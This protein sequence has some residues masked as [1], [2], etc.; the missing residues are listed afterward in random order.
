M[1]AQPH[2]H[3]DR[4]PGP[5]DSPRR[6]S[7][8]P[9]GGNTASGAGR[10]SR[11]ERLACTAHEAARL[12]SLSRVLRYDQMRRSN[13]VGVKAGRWRLLTCQHQLFPGIAS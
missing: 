12:A 6:T 5:A 11:G 8:P 9:P 13:L 4:E 10:H 7:G 1:T 3:R 2:Q